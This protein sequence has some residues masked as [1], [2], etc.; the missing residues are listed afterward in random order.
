MS[1]ES[2]R[3]SDRERFQRKGFLFIPGAL[4]AAEASGLRRECQA[5][6]EPERA[7]GGLK[8][9]KWNVVQTNPRFLPL[10]DN[11]KV[12]QGLLGVLGPFIHLLSSEAWVR[13]V[14]APPEPWHRDGGPLMRHM[15]D[16]VQVK[17]QFF[18]T[19]VEGRRNGNLTLI[20]GSHHW[21]MPARIRASPE[22]DEQAK[23]LTVKAGDA[24]IWSGNMWHRVEPNAAEVDRVSV[25]LAYGLLWVRP[26]DYDVLEESFLEAASPLQRLLLSHRPQGFER[27]QYFYP[28]DTEHRVRLF[29]ERVG[30]IA[31]D[32]TPTF[33][34]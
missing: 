13:A 8:F 9:V 25:I 29:E 16:L 31:G 2:S 32:L 15:R 4:D 26:Y 23:T 7:N 20:P 19:D 6:Y 14:G 33:V 3:E 12:L 1:R 10:L 17:V 11:R 24:V 22:L 18:L 27:G 5:L 30:P 34:A 28:A 21:K